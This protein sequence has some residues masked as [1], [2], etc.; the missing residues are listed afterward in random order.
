MRYVAKKVEEVEAEQFT[1]EMAA[2]RNKWPK[3]VERRVVPHEGA[4]RAL[5]TGVHEGVRFY[6]EP[7]DY[8]VR[9]GRGF[10]AV[11]KETFEATFVPKAQP[12]AKDD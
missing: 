5:F 3:G 11:A 9:A 4:P 6:F 8:L 10:Y 7:G 2:N 1:D 12:K